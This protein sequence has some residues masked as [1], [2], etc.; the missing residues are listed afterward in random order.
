MTFFERLMIYLLPCHF[1]KGKGGFTEDQG[2]G[3]HVGV[4]C[5]ECGGS[6][7]RLYRRTLD[8]HTS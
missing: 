6:G 8:E 3:H 4:E 2:Y 5:P 7:T 1:C